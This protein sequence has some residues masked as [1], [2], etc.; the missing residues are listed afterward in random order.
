[1]GEHGCPL[2]LNNMSLISR[3][4]KVGAFG[5]HTLGPKCDC[6]CGDDC[7]GDPCVKCFPECDACTSTSAP[8]ATI[9]VDWLRVDASGYICDYIEYEVVTGTLSYDRYDG[10]LFAIIYKGSVT[11]K[12]Y[13]RDNFELSEDE[14][15]CCEEDAVL[16]STDTEEVEVHLLC[17]PTLNGS[18]Y[19]V[20]DFDSVG[21][22]GD[23]VQVG[24]DTCYGASADTVSLVHPQDSSFTAYDV[25]CANINGI[26][27]DCTADTG[28]TV[29]ENMTVSPG[30]ALTIDIPSCYSL[31]DGVTTWQ[32]NQ[33]VSDP[34]KWED[35]AVAFTLVR[36]LDG[37]GSPRWRL[38]RNVDA[39]SDTDD[40]DCFCDQTTSVDFV[41]DGTTYTLTDGC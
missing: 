38:T 13:R 15:D 22:F 21:F 37:S 7:D 17:G 35:A 24:L 34:C 16:V 5:S 19:I 32:L 40:E 28:L 23:L 27:K 31:T 8:P 4:Y 18:Y 11:R 39:E 20:V 36:E 14:P 33:N 25:C 30:P 26:Y 9:D 29:D 2:V 41:V 12:L 1:M 3:K 10:G 6:D